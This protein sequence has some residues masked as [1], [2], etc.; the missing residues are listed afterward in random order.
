MFVRIGLLQ[1]LLAVSTEVDLD[2]KTRGIRSVVLSRL[3]P[4]I[5]TNYH[6]NIDGHGI[7][8]NV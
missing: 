6:T 5:A 4:I 7:L 3:V 8:E 1:T 2:E